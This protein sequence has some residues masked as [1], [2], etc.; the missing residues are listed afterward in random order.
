MIKTEYIGS[1]ELIL[2]V[3]S[4][5]AKLNFKSFQNKTGMMTMLT[6]WSFHLHKKKLRFMSL[7]IYI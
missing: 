7:K 2:P 3:G 4:R 6:E 5:Y 1:L